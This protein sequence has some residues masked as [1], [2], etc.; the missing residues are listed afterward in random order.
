MQFAALTALTRFKQFGESEMSENSR[1][2]VVPEQPGFD[3]VEPC[4]NER[5]TVDRLPFSAD[6][7]GANPATAPVTI[8]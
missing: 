6:R 7:S 5:G 4:R 2:I 3:L 8:T 1:L